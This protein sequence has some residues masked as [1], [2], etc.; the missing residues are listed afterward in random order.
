MR[1]TSLHRPAQRL[2]RAG[3]ITRHRLV[4]DIES[5][6]LG[7]PGVVSAHRGPVDIAIGIGDQLRTSGRQFADVRTDG[8]DHDGHHI[9]VHLLPQ[10]TKLLVH[11]VRPLGGLG[12]ACAV[13]NRGAQ[14]LQRGGQRLRTT[15]ARMLDEQKGSGRQIGGRLLDEGDSILTGLGSRLDDDDSFVGEQRRTQQFGEFGNIHLTRAQPIDRN[16]GSCFTPD[17]VQYRGHRTLDQ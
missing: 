8:V 16:I 7:A 1:H 17:C 2:R 9:G 3:D 11:E 5:G 13:V 14:V 10:A 6:H 4:G 15:A 12:D